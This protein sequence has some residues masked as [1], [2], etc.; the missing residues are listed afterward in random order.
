MRR[1]LPLSAHWADDESRVDIT[2]D[3]I[4]EATGL[5]RLTHNRAIVHRDV[6]ATAYDTRLVYGGHVQALAQASL[7]PDGATLGTIVAWHACSH[8]APSV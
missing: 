5:V 8:L 1:Q 3:I 6:D 4:D 7:T 2:R